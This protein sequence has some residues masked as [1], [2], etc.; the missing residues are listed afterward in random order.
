MTTFKSIM[1]Y[2]FS[3]SEKI[4]PVCSLVSPNNQNSLA[5]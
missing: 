5:T 1:F 3:T 2:K 4:K